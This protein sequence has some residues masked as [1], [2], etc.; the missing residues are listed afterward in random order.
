MGSLDTL[1]LQM[2]QKIS[3]W[4]QDWIGVD[5]FKIARFLLVIQAIIHV[6]SITLAYIILDA[7]VFTA[8]L[9][10][11]L[12]L[13][14]RNAYAAIIMFEEKQ[15]NSPNFLNQAVYLLASER[16]S[17]IVYAAFAMIPIIGMF[18]SLDTPHDLK[19]LGKVF[20]TFLSFIGIIKVI[21]YYFIS[22]TP[23]PKKPSKIKQLVNKISESFTPATPEFAVVKV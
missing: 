11:G 16:T 20:V 9:A 5:N 18:Q 21:I 2:F 15:K 14:S 19:L 12:V 17:S 1:L 6:A 3:D 7:D 23:K 13:M 10:V 22:C 8:I 4:F